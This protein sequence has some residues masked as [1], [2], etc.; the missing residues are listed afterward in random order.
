M[1][2]T[3]FWGDNAVCWDSRRCLCLW[4]FFSVMNYHL[5]ASWLVWRSDMAV[6]L[7]LRIFILK[8][9]SPQVNIYT[10]T[11]FFGCM[12]A[13]IC[14]VMPSDWC[15]LGGSL[16]RQLIS[17]RRS[18]TQIFFLCYLCRLALY[19]LAVFPSLTVH[20]AAMAVSALFVKACS[21]NC[22][23]T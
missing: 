6:V 7:G 12:D 16:W 18:R 13:S 9:S 2:E 15:R 21:W 23:C 8:W 20:W 22:R 3:P 11:S 4:C 10:R 5:F 19:F 1:G 14:I 17:N